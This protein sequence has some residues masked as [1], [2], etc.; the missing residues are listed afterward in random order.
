[1]LRLAAMQQPRCD[2]CQK[3]A[4]NTAFSTVNAVDE[5]IKTY[6]HRCDARMLQMQCT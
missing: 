4:N 2:S 1:M 5:A 3:H 6:T